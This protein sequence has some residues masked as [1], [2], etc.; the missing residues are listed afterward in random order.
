M[1]AHLFVY[2]G[3][4]RQLSFSALLAVAVF[5]DV[6]AQRRGDEHG[7]A[8]AAR[9]LAVLFLGPCEVRSFGFHFGGVFRT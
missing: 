1:A 9:A 3:P 8:S 5:V 4:V 7:E 2:V 6:P